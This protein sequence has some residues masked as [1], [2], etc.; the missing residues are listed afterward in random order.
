MAK[1]TRKTEKPKVVQDDFTKRILDVFN[2]LA[3]IPAFHRVKQFT[4]VIN[5]EMSNW[6]LVRTGERNF[7]QR[8]RTE[9]M[10][11]LQ[12][13]FGVNKLYLMG[14]AGKKDMYTNKPAPIDND[15]PTDYLML[16]FSNKLQKKAIIDKVENLQDENEKLKQQL[17]ILQ[18]DNEAYKRIQEKERTDGRTDKPA[19]KPKK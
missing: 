15:G 2:D 10:S 19:K 18:E 3:L 6:G 8:K 7:P 14:M 17:M 5:Y 9:A 13:H 16:E 1:S 12:K 11:A 4:S